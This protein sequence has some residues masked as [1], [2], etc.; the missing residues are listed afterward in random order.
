ML[1]TEGPHLVAMGCNVPE[2]R[3][4]LAQWNHEQGANAVSDGG[5]LDGRN[6]V[7]CRY[8]RNVDQSLALQQLLL[9]AT[10]GRPKWRAQQ[11]A[12]TG[13]KRPHRRGAK[14]LAV[15]DH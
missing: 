13:R 6:R 4:I 7:P 11:F 1:I 12:E 9:G 2:Q 10:G 3:G 8:I 14:M 15:I 5:L